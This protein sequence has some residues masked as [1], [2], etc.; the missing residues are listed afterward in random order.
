MQAMPADIH[1]PTAS[2]ADD[3]EIVLPWFLG[4]RRAEMS[5]LGEGQIGCTM[6]ENGRYVP[7]AETASPSSFPAG[8][9]DYLR[10]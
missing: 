6:R 10:R 9:R 5:F 7:G 4:Q 2:Y 8:L 1:L 3:G